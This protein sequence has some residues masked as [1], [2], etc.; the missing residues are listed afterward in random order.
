MTQPTDRRSDA[1][2]VDACNR[3]DAS[4]AT[5]AFEILYVRHRAYVLRVAQRFARDRDIAA[6]ALQETFAY[7]L[8]QFPPT[9]KG[10]TLTARLTT[11][12]YPVAKN[13]ALSAARK[14]RRLETGGEAEIEALADLTP[15]EPQGGDVI[16]RALTGL[17]TERRE[18]L[19]L[20]FVDD[21][22]LEEIATALEIPLG[23][24]KSRLHL[25]LKQLR[26]DPRIKDLFA[27]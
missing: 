11:F 6:D 25:A 4:A 24:V 15:G 1:E 20:R 17:S 23:T 10:F 2:L 12:L 19:V 9:G 27:P 21:L 7:L 26:E 22:S 16:D 3:A 13:F 18:V 5:A 14:D 8:K